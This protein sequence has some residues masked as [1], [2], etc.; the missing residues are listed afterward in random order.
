MLKLA[1][2]SFLKKNLKL[3]NAKKFPCKV[4]TVPKCRCAKLSPFKCKA[5]CKKFAV[6]NV[7][8]QNCPLVQKLPLVIK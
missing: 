4:D 1:L 8:V 7:A 5:P 3:L 6:K 2:N